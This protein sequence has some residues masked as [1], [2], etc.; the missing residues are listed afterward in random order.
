MREEE[1]S[2]STLFPALRKDEG[3]SSKERGSGGE[4]EKTNEV[5]VD[6]VFELADC[7]SAIRNDTRVSLQLL[8]LARKTLDHFGC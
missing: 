8:K 3:A 2:D 7:S 5:G 4:E 6:E 1:R